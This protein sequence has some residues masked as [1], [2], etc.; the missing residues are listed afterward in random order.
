MILQPLREEDYG[1][2]LSSWRESHK[3]SPGVDKLPWSFYKKD[4]GA[5]FAALINSKDTV[6]IGAYASHDGPLLGWLVMSP[7]KRVDVVHWVQVKYELDG[8]R[9]RRHGIMTALLHAADLGSSFVYTLRARRDRAPLPDGGMSK[10]LDETLAA[11]LG[12]KG[13]SATYVELKKW[14]A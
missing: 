10:S 2:C 12:G 14:M 8:E 6:K 4:F 1:Y 13:I 11:A 7:G 9:L 3:A 5:L